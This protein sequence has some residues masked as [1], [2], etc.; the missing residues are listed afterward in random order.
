[1]DQRSDSDAALRE[2]GRRQERLAEL[3]QVALE[4]S[5]TDELLH[6][7]AEAA[8]DSLE[9][10]YVAVFERRAADELLLREGVGWRTDA[11]GT[12]T[13]TADEDSW[14]W[15][16]LTSEEP[17]V[18]DVEGTPESDLLEGHDAVGGVGVV[19]GPVAD[20]W[21]VLSV[22]TTEP[23][24]FTE[25]DG[26]F[27]QRVA[28]VLASALDREG[29]NNQ[30]RLE[31]Y[32]AL[33]QAANDAIVTIDE[34]SVVQSVNP[35][36]EDIFGYEPAELVGEPLAM[37]MA[38]DVA[39]RHFQA[40]GNYLETGEKNLDWD[41]VEAPGR[42]RDG[43]EIPL[44]ISFSEAEYDGERF[45]TGIVRDVTE[46]KEYERKLEASN[47]RLEQFA[48]AASH[49]LQ[50]PLRMV[51][52]YLQLVE[53]RYGE[54]LD[55]DGREFIEFAVD[56]AER[57]RAMIEGLLEYSRVETQ[58]DPFEPVDLDGVLSDVLDDL[59]V[60]VEE[61]DAAITH[62]PLPVVDGDPGQLRQL[63]QNLLDNAIEYSGDEPPRVDVTAERQAG[64]WVVS[65]RDEGIGIDAENA[66]RVFEV[67]QR[68]HSQDEHAGTGIGLALCERIVERHGGD[69]RVDSAP[70]EGT[71]FSFTLPTEGTYSG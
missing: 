22:H 54:D 17:V 62:D 2:S 13:V 37:L 15:G 10:A 71:T 69:I 57:M 27:L 23:R 32:R 6:H 70:G 46:R 58:G 60:R 47:E 65:V 48:Y 5:D 7:A 3:G 55:E 25:H 33:T 40:L 53:D 61:T 36:V 66:D 39:E 63:F 29:S 4:T 59:Q 67:F 68:L 28:G 16:V 50:E 41:L 42:H 45:F 26:A 21:G 31:Q 34:R 52:S 56:G 51:S 19:V 9:A 44:A 14:L 30:R 8:A 1:M 20:P 49:D 64:E 11:V 18:A 24:A 12:A 43:T 38:S 35:A